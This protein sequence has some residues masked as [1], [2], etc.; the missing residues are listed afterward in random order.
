MSKKADNVIQ[1]LVSRIVADRKVL[2]STSNELSEVSCEKEKYK[3]LWDSAETN[4][5]LLEGLE[6]VE[7]FQRVQSTC[8]LAYKVIM[9]FAAE[10]RE[11]LRVKQEYRQ[12]LNEIIPGKR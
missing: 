1:I 10:H 11:L 6:G 7:T 3:K 9:L 8:D 4:A 12:Q 2:E 5:K